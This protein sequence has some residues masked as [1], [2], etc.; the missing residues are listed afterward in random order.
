MKIEV[1]MPK[2][3]ES[4]TEGTILKWHKKTGDPVKKDEILFEISTDKVDTEIPA[5]NEGFMGD[6]L[7]L[8]NDTVEVGTVVAY[9][10]DSAQKPNETPVAPT[11]TKTEVA[12]PSEPV[13]QV[14]AQKQ[15][16]VEFSHAIEIPMP[17]MGESVM[18]GTIIKWHKKVGDSVK[19]EETLFEISTDKVDTEVPSPEEGT[20][21]EILV[22]EQQTVE[23]G[24]IV[25]RIGSQA[26]SA[27]SKTAHDTVAEN[28]SKPI[29][30][31]AISEV[32]F[33]TSSKLENT[34]D[35]FFSP[36]VMNIAAAEGITIAE[37]DSLKGTGVGGRVTK[38]DVLEYLENRKTQIVEKKTIPSQATVVTPPVSV[39]VQSSMP[40]P[41]TQ[42]YAQGS[43]D[44][45][46]M[47]NIRIKIMEHMV[48]SRETSVHVTGIIEVDMTAIDRF[49]KKNKDQ[50]KQSEGVSLTFMPFIAQAVVKGLKE[51]P[52]MNASID[53]TS[54]VKKKFINL[55]VAVALEPNGLIVP[56]IK[57]AQDKSVVG[58]ARSIKDL[59]ERSRTK[60]LT[61]DDISSGTFT[62]TN[63]GVFGTIIGTPIINQPEVAILGIGAVQ[64]KPVVVEVDGY[65]TIAIKSMMYLTLSHDHRLVDGMLGGKFLK[66]VKDTL[67]NFNE[68]NM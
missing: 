32:E 51:F 34:S 29:N 33:E 68:N 6:I 27:A 59:A 36:L 5:T 43:V 35:K 15:D 18:E 19:K 62:L 10:V 26:G 46:P 65:D 66:Y 47:D 3:G 7:F 21:L 55:G 20:V 39:R 58:L 28:A 12:V 17:K 23:V 52:F 56:N 44:I 53:G 16:K 50:Y 14:T 57:N 30:D 13:S 42:V 31:V 24:T 2:M 4:V 1:V 11:E 64:K 61:P 38:K 40:Q 67:E 49:I 45:Q 9:L 63:Y 8:E 22:Q 37:L 54:I 41:P 60:K 48:R 25:A